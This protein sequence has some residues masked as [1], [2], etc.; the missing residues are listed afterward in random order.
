MMEPSTAEG[1]VGR[2]PSTLEAIQAVFMQFPVK[3]NWRLIKRW[4]K[5]PQEFMAFLA[6]GMQGLLSS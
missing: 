4:T 6:G 3:W 5:I 2:N 1:I